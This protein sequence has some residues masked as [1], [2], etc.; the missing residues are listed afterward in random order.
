MF[1]SLEVCDES[2]GHYCVRANFA[3]KPNVATL[4][5]MRKKFHE[6]KQNGFDLYLQLQEIGSSIRITWLKPSTLKGKTST[7]DVTSKKNALQTKSPDVQVTST[8]TSTVTRDINY[9]DPKTGRTAL[10]ASIVDERVRAAVELLTAGARTDLVDNYGQ[11]ALEIALTSSA[12]AQLIQALVVCSTPETI[13]RPMRSGLT[14]LLDV[15]IRHRHRLDQKLAILK[16]LLQKGANVNIYSKEQ[17]TVLDEVLR[18]DGGSQLLWCILEY[19]HDVDVNLKS[20]DDKTILQTLLE[21]N[22]LLKDVHKQ[23]IDK[24]LELGADVS[25][26]MDMRF[27]TSKLPILFHA[28]TNDWDVLVGKLIDRGADVNQVNSRGE[29]VLVY[30]ISYSYA[31]VKLIKMLVERGIPVNTRDNVGLT[32]LRTALTRYSRRLHSHVHGIENDRNN[33]L[34]IVNVLLEAGANINDGVLH[35]FV[36]HRDA[37]IVKYL[38]ERGADVNG[39][40]F[41]GRTVL[42]IEP[43]DDF[44]VFQKVDILK[45]L[46]NAGLSPEIINHQT[47]DGRTFL[48]DL[49]DVPLEQDQEGPIQQAYELLELFMAHGADINLYDHDGDNL[50]TLIV[51]SLNDADIMNREYY[52]GLIAILNEYEHYR[53]LEWQPDYTRYYPNEFRQRLAELKKYAAIRNISKAMFTSMAQDLAKNYPL[54]ILRNRRGAVPDIAIPTPAT[55]ETEIKELMDTTPQLADAKHLAYI[56]FANRQS[57][58]QEQ[59]ITFDQ[60]RADHA[61]TSR[62]MDLVNAMIFS[63]IID[64]VVDMAYDQLFTTQLVRKEWPLRMVMR[65]W[66][67]RER[68][69]RRIYEIVKERADVQ[70]LSVEDYFLTAAHS[71]TRSSQRNV[72]NPRELTKSLLLSPEN[73]PDLSVDEMD[74]VRDYLLNKTKHL[75]SDEYQLLDDLDYYEMRLLSKTSKEPVNVFDETTRRQGKWKGKRAADESESES[76][77]ETEDEFGRESE[78]KP[79]SGPTT[80]TRRDGNG[81]ETIRV[82]SHFSPEVTDPEVLFR[83]RERLANFTEKQLHLLQE[84]LESG[85]E[86]MRQLSETTLIRLMQNI[87]YELSLKTDR[88]QDEERENDARRTAQEDAENRTQEEAF[89]ARLAEHVDREPAFHPISP[90]NPACRVKLRIHSDDGLVESQTLTLTTLTEQTTLASLFYAVDRIIQ[91]SVVNDQHQVPLVPEILDYLLETRDGEAYSRNDDHRTLG[92]LALCQSLVTVH[93]GM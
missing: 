38:L 10:M 22:N 32:P 63:E 4:E 83:H 30:A 40:D 18:L 70:N 92:E 57:R 45:M 28:V 69:F 76:E 51:L 24:V 31:N 80:G 93:L 55:M 65:N 78:N 44:I 86:E 41:N 14:L 75:S 5:I 9:Q 50:Y 52:E 67:Q 82:P 54:V 88:A 1:V 73:L 58:G 56:V 91:D 90:E 42:E 46:L 81:P 6:Y 25:S 27:G 7:T 37:E 77:S 62:F 59:P 20:G 72:V 84:Y 3:A 36:H 23:L 26:V 66:E 79:R 74:S 47:T 34:Q 60:I 61:L 35:T 48:M 89:M 43:I 8:I 17:R 12:D 49:D 16:D 21:S 64:D 85:P 11:T 15:L 53:G 68:L 29:T 87:E 19:G 2:A 33:A 71:K 13:N 39:L